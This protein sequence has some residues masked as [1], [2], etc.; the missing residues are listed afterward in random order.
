M[1]GSPIL[2]NDL[3]L[4]SD[5]EAV[6]TCNS[7]SRC[8]TWKTLEYV[9]QAMHKDIQ[10]QCRSQQKKNSGNNAMGPLA[11][12]QSF[13]TAVNPRSRPH[14]SELRLCVNTAGPRK[15]NVAEKKQVTKESTYSMIPFI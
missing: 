9:P 2:E 13:K 11:A 3:A 5:T 1:M 12:E 8:T 6:W 14:S 7:T 10:Q 4:N 15:H